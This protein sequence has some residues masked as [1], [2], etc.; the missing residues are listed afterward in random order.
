MACIAVR[1]K[2][3]DGCN[4]KPIQDG[5]CKMHLNS[6]K[7]KGYKEWTIN[8]VNIR[9]ENERIVLKNQAKEGKDM[10]EELAVLNLR[11]RI[12][13]SST[14]K[15]LHDMEDSPEDIAWRD[16]LR[17]REIRR[18][19]EHEIRFERER[20]EQLDRNAAWRP[21]ENQWGEIPPIAVPV[22]VAFHEDNQNIHREVTVN[23]VV[24]NTIQKV[25]TIRVPADYGWN[26]ETVAKTPGE[27]I[28]ECKLSIAAGK[29]LMEKYTSDETI[30]DMVSGIYGKTLDSVWQY[31]KNSSDKAVLIKTLKIELED[32]IGMCAQGNLTRLCN[33]LQGYLDEMPK[34]SIA[35]ILGD[36]LPP[37]MAIKDRKV[38][39]EKALQIMRTHNVP[40]DQHGAWLDELDDDDADEERRV[41]LDSLRM[42]YYP[43]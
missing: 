3:A 7:L 34:P 24:K 43:D 2:K 13:T 25:I 9:F 18:Q 12:Q 28:A 8:Q 32:N 42:D 41:Y 22:P 19:R 11:W 10:S 5:L 27:I 37:L 15:T 1:Y 29:L 23:E 31:I 35:E 14:W 33:V 40:D 26:M 21:N 39:R 6:K 20:Q 4:L 38:R 30:Y 36:L 17:S 16:T